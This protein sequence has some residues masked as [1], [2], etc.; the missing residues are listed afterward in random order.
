VVQEDLPLRALERSKF[1]RT[2]FVAKVIV[3]TSIFFLIGVVAL[4]F[5]ARTEEVVIARGIVKPR[6]DYE[7]HAT[8]PAVLVDVKFRGGEA[9]KAGELMAQADDKKLCD[10]LTR[11]KGQIIEAE[12]QLGVLQL[13]VARLQ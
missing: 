8:E 7:V 11:K 4:L 1:R 9:V 12:G 10:E 13:K 3:Y 5:V 2:F 6:Y